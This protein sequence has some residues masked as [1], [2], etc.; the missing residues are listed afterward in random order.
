MESEQGLNQAQL[1][2]LTQDERAKST[3]GHLSPDSKIRW[4]EVLTE[5]TQVLRRAQG[6]APKPAT[7]STAQIK[8]RRAAREEDRE[9]A[10][11]PAE[12][13]V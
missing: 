12:A 11:V 1:T 9:E 10:I 5:A 8:P 6:P 7:S 2:E 13:E 3:T 4:K